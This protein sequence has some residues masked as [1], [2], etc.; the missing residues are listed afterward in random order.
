MMGMQVIQLTRT[1]VEKY[2]FGEGGSKQFVGALRSI[3]YILVGDATVI[4]STG[5]HSHP[6]LF[7]KYLE[8]SG[9]RLPRT[10]TSQV[11]Y[12]TKAQLREPL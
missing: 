4:G 7:R 2:S 8:P 5:T 11:V 6:K 1:Q 3:S 10:H 12:Q 9:K